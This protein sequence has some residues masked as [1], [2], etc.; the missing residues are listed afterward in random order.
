MTLPVV[1]FIGT[2]GTIASL[3]STPLDVLDYGSTGHL[4]SADEI[5]ARFPEVA[6]VANVMPVAYRAVPSSRIFFD[7]WKALAALCTQLERDTPDLAGIVIGHGTGS[8]EET[9]Y[10]LSLTLKVRLPLSSPAASAPPPPSPPMP[11]STWSTP[12]APPPPPRRA[13]WACWCC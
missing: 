9:A 13:A 3:G 1:A 10:F 7:D 5:I 4:L 11:G 6:L 2:G 12:S 8:L